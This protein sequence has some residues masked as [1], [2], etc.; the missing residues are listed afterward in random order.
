MLNIS[1]ITASIPSIKKFLVDVQSGLM[2]VTI[3]EMYEMTHSGGKPTQVL[4]GSRSRLDSKSGSRLGIFSN[5]S[6]KSQ[7]MSGAN[8]SQGGRE[9]PDSEVRDGRYGNAAYAKPGKPREQIRETESVKGLKNNAIYQ[10]VDYDV[11]YEHRSTELVEE[12]P[13]SDGRDRSG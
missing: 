12:R 2:G 4:S 8:S 9:H 11:E 10:T 5:K 1:I 6:N 13:W 7:G 3:S